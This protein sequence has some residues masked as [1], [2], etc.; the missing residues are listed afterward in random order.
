MELD[1][2][3][4]AITQGGWAALAILMFWMYTRD[5]K[6]AQDKLIEMSKFYSNDVKENQ[7]K[8]VDTAA[9]YM[10]FGEKYAESLT[11]IS[12]SLN[13]Q[14]R[15]LEKIEDHLS[16][17]DMFSDVPKELLRERLRASEV[18]KRRAVDLTLLHA[19]EPPQQGKAS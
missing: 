15:T 9:A 8:L 5:S 18:P 7:T 10:S 2:I 6:S 3:K 17:V 19:L 1:V 13:Y 12:E 4:W 11:K 16:K 14:A